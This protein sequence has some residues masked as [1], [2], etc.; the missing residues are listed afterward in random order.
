MNNLLEKWNR[1]PKEWKTIGIAVGA[2]ALLG[3]V[4]YYMNKEKVVL[5]DDGNLTVN[6][7]VKIF[8][9]LLEE[10]KADFMKYVYELRQK[11]R[12]TANLDEYI[13]LQKEFESDVESLLMLNQNKVLRQFGCSQETF[14][15]SIDYYTRSNNP[16]IRALVT[17]TFQNLQD[18]LP[19]RKV[20][21]RQDF[22]TIM[23]YRIQFINEQG[24]QL[25][26]EVKSTMQSEGLHVTPGNVM[27]FIQNKIGDQ[28]FAKF[29]TEREDL[30]AFQKKQDIENDPELK[31]ILEAS[32]AATTKAFPY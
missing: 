32:V 25:L 13:S 6:S 20:V 17:R 11:R 21:T 31:T 10:S 4:H 23:K 24:R 30:L 28:I 22:M 1:L 15:N 19:S 3:G 26:Q 27:P 7:I 8:S 5:A 14:E 2:A 18:T 16:E 29:E 9:R 12:A